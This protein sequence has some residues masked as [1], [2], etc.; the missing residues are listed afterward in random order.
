LLQR[1]DAGFQSNYARYGRPPRAANNR[2]HGW[3]RLP[4][5]ILKVRANF[6]RLL[7]GIGAW[8]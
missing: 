8:R 7:S 5:F 1:D 3:G 4:A 6:G 2:S